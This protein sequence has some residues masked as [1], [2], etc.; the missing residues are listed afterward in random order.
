MRMYPAKSKNCLEDMNF[1]I[2]SSLSTRIIVLGIDGI[3]VALPVTEARRL[4]DALVVHVERLE[5][6][7]ETSGTETSEPS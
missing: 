6:K 2:E 7:T 1:T 4:S 5:A 3:C